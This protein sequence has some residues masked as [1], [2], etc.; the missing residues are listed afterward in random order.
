[1]TGTFFNLNGIFKQQMQ[2]FYD[3]L[4]D[5]LDLGNGNKIVIFIH[6]DLA[7]VIARAKICNCHQFNGAYGCI[8]C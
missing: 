6:G 2:D 4:R 8:Y 3:L 1:M 7:D 5:G